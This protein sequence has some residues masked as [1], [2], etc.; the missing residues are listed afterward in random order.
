M[1]DNNKKKGSYFVL[2]ARNSKR[3]L[4]YSLPSPS[5]GDMWMKGQLFKTKPNEPVVAEI[6]S[7]YEHAELMPYFDEPQLISDAFHEALVEAGV[8]N[9]DVI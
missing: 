4:C 2:T 9:I 1:S 5:R 8:D 7:G 3:M 6:I